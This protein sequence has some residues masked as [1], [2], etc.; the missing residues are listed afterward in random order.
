M[1]EAFGLFIKWGSSVIN[2][3]IEEMKKI[4]KMFNKHLEGVCN[5]LISSF[6]N[7]MA[8]RLNGKIQ[9]VKSTTRG[10][11]HSIIL[12]VQYFSLTVV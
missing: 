1:T 8:E 2:S 4:A 3:K 6:S 9:E 7:A 11:E 10:T 12:E 5:A